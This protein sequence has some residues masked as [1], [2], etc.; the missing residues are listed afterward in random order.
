M[1]YWRENGHE[2]W[3][4]RV[5]PDG[6]QIDTFHGGPETIHLHPPTDYDEI[7]RLP[8]RTLSEVLDV[9]FARLAEGDQLKLSAILEDLTR[10]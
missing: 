8:P 2:E 9:V 3:V 6:L 5:E 10:P 4:V 1:V 7:L